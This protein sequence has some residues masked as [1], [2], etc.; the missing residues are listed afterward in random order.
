MAKAQVWVKLNQI[1]MVE[2]AGQMK[3][4]PVGARLQVPKRLA[5]KW[6]QEGAAKVVSG[7][8]TGAVRQEQ[9]LQPPAPEPKPKP[10]L[11]PRHPQFA[12]PSELLR[13]A[14]RWW[15]NNNP[16]PLP[17][18]LVPDGQAFM[19]LPRSMV[20][21]HG[22]PDPTFNSCPTCQVAE[23]VSRLLQMDRFV[24]HRC[25]SAEDC[26]ALCSRQGKE[27]WT[28][29]Q[30]NFWF[31]RG[32]DEGLNAPRCALFFQT[33]SYNGWWTPGGSHVTI[34]KRRN[35][36]RACQVDVYHLT[37]EVTVDWERYDF[38]FIHNRRQVPL[39]ERPPV[40]VVMYG[41]DMWK[42]N[43]QE[44]L[45]HYRPEILLT[46]FPSLWKKEMRIPAGTEVRLYAI[47]ASQ[48]FTRPNPDPARKSLDLLCIGALSND[49][50]YRPRKQLH[51]QILNLPPR[52]AV[53]HSHQAQHGFARADEPLDGRKNTFLNK[54]SETLGRARFVIFAGC[55]DKAAPMMLI[56]YYEVL[57]SGAVPVMPP[58]GDLALLGVEA[59][60]HYVDVGKVTGDN[61]AL[62]R[63]LDRYEDY[64]PI[65]ERAA[66]W[67][68]EQADRLLFGGFEEVVREVTGHEYP[69]RLVEG[70]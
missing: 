12:P 43:P 27:E 45:D 53:G 8:R 41:H 31:A 52:Y 66:E 17:I 25:P 50:F 70:G 60:V 21:T 11:A 36:G 18:P 6:A 20:A 22:G 30:Q 13:D 38:A 40:P 26:R 28:H 23:W 9:I 65:A 5:Y 24:D 1:K 62:A 59:G 54:Y 7:P 14:R 68:R 55:S 3:R 67:H 56:K 35:F 49:R 44:T 4:Y 61:H 32:V 64:R 37:P 15:F 42:G 16:D 39:I 34:N 58:V 46:P 63:M 10:P 69:A 47:S 33:R 29:L 51:A 48:F 57:G 2:V 19:Q